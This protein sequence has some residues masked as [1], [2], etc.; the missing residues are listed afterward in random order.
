M[1]RALLRRPATLLLDV[2]H[3]FQDRIRHGD[4]AVAATGPAVKDS[5]EHLRGQRY[6]LL[7]TFRRSGAPVPTPV[8]FGMTDDYRLYLNTVSH[9][10]KVKRIRSD[11]RVRVAPCT[12]RGNPRIV[13]P[14]E[15]AAAE[16]VIRANYRAGREMFQRLVGNNVDS[17]YIEIRSAHSPAA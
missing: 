12:F 13:D 5:F 6:C 11:S 17:V 14:T 3:A 15:H 1:A 16:A 4:A 9:S 2:E 10:L 8:W 7:V